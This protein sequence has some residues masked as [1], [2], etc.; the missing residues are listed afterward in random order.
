MALTW[1]VASGLLPDQERP[2]DEPAGAAA[3]ARASVRCPDGRAEAA[4]GGIRE[5][6]ARCGRDQSVAADCFVASRRRARRTIVTRPKGTTPRMAAS[7]RKSTGEITS[8]RGDG[9]VGEE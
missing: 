3:V 7:R 4:V 8:D 6:G 1:L 9:A 5:R 2:G